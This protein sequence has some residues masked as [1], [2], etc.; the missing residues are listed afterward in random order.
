M[1]KMW[2]KLNGNV[3]ED[4]R[5]GRAKE[6]CGQDGS[7]AQGEC[8]EVGNK[9][10]ILVADLFVY[11]FFDRGG[12]AV[13]IGATHDVDVRKKFHYGGK[14]GKKL[15]KC[16]L[17]ILRKTKCL[18]AASR[19]EVQIIKAYKRRGEAKLNIKT[20]AT[21]LPA[22]TAVPVYWLEGGILFAGRKQCADYFFVSAGT[23]TTSIRDYDGELGFSCD[24]N[25]KPCSIFDT[26]HDT[27]QALTYYASAHLLS[28]L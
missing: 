4:G 24:E 13:Y 12:R 3:Q 19:I 28:P 8:S 7:S 22:T 5:E 25:G 18:D 14:H 9:A 10:A 27:E 17:R 6:V 15:R 16:D 20:R 11:G 21:R 26:P 1:S 2:N 23:V